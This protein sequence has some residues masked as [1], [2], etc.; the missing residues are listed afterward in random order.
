LNEVRNLFHTKAAWLYDR[1]SFLSRLA[2]AALPRGLAF[3]APHTQQSVDMGIQGSEFS[4][5]QGPITANSAFFTRN[6][7]NAP[8]LSSSAWK[9]RVTGMV[10]TPLEVAYPELVRQPSTSLTATVECAG[11]P[12]GGAGVGTATWTGIGLRELLERAGLQ[13]GVKWIRLVGAD[14][15]SVEE[16]FGLSIPYSRSIPL[17]KAL[18]PETIL[19][20]QMNSLPLPTA[21]GYPLRA[22]VTGWYGMDSVKWLQGIEA[23]DHEDQGYFMTQRYVATRLLAVGSERRPLTQMRVK[24][25]IARPR[26]GEILP[27]APY[28]IRGA[29]WAGEKKIAGVEVSADGGKSWKQATLEAAPQPYAWVLW[30]F[31]WAPQSP[32]TYTLIVRAAD[33]EGT[34]QLR[35]P[36]LL[37]LDDYEDNWWHTVKCSVR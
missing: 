27:L 3:Q 34:T 37:R 5:L 19:A 20:Y 13:P 6:H 15:G 33:D 8:V 2:L 11:N 14:Q 12:V 4:S 18:K 1:R 35:S 9:L 10:R 29:A 24:S 7:F 22:I 23:L 25:Q 28:T 16:P 31:E 21:H 32:G 17:D 26:A 30:S 36:D